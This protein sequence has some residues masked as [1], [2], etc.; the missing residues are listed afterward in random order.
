VDYIVSASASASVYNDY[1]YA[2][3]SNGKALN[4]DVNTGHC[5]SAFGGGGFNS[6]QPLRQIIHVLKEHVA[7]GYQGQISLFKS[8]TGAVAFTLNPF[9]VQQAIL[10]GSQSI[11]NACFY[12]VS[13]DYMYACH[14]PIINKYHINQKKHILC[15]EGHTDSILSLVVGGS[16]LF[17][18]SRDNTIKKWD[19]NSGA[20]LMLN[21]SN[22]LLLF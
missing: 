15:F 7:V 12:T 6:S 3:S 21:K 4:F 1:L 8:D 20:N 11:Q 18:R 22:P 16:F 14:G 17:T 9:Q 2:V 5:I 19:I 13:G 10:F